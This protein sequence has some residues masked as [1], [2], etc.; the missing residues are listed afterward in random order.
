MEISVSEQVFT[1]K[2]KPEIK[3]HFGKSLEIKN[4]KNGDLIPVG[5][6]SIFS[7]ELDMEIVADFSS[8]EDFFKE[9]HEL[10]AERD[11]VDLRKKLDSK[12]M[13]ID[14][15]LF[16]KIYAFSQKLGEKY[17]YNSEFNGS[18]NEMNR[19]KI[20]K[21]KGK[22]TKLSDIF[23]TNSEQCAEIAILAQG[24]LQSEGINSSYF[25]GEVLWK[26]DHEF[27]E[28][29]SFIIIRENDKQYVYDPSNP[30]INKRFPSIYSMD[31]NFDEEV[32]KGQKIF[33]TANNIRDKSEAFYG[34]GDMTTVYP[35][36]HIV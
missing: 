22:E 14:E 11:L 9:A 25:S 30:M 13:D 17:L 36:K 6:S 1:E 24:F 3:Q 28:P 33:V 8:F 2:N 20:Y 16:S 5:G 34:T 26:R 4:I 21:E 35:E 19:K 32:A 12:D 10:V 27:G 18:E 15:K 7:N 29:H 31:K 23:N